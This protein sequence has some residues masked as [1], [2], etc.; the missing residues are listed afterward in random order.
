VRDGEVLA[1]AIQIRWI[2]V[3]GPGQLNSW[4]LSVGFAMNI[5]DAVYTYIFTTPSA[6]DHNR[7]VIFPR[8]KCVMLQAAI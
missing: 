7:L 8:H 2:Q 4:M 6:P 3:A 1:K 5:A